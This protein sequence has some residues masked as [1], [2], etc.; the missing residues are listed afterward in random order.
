MSRL[1]CGCLTMGRIA[2]LSNKIF[3]QDFSGPHRAALFLFRGNVRT[4]F[5]LSVFGSKLKS[6][7]QRNCRIKPCFSLANHVNFDT[8]TRFVE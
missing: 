4:M 5:V 6:T 3:Y 7:V 2:L 1:S 8:I